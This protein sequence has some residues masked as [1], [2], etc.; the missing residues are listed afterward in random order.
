MRAAR[1]T[2][3]I[4][5]MSVCTCV[6]VSS[7]TS[8]RT[9]STCSRLIFHL[10]HGGGEQDHHLRVR[11]L[12]CLLELRGGVRDGADLHLGQARDDQREPD[13]AQ[14][15]HRVLLVQIAPS[16]DKQLLVLLGRIIA[17]ER[18]TSQYGFHGR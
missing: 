7:S 2:S 1:G 6:P 17:G 3:I 8:L 4:V 18:D 12:A 10:L 9:S 15:E 16:S 11:V 5:P 13:A 14:A